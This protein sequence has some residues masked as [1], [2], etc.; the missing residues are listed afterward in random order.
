MKGSTTVNGFDGCLELVAHAG[1]VQV[2]LNSIHNFPADFHQTTTS[3]NTS[4]SAEYD[5]DSKPSTIIAHDGK[6]SCIIDPEI[7]TWL[8]AETTLA[9][10]TAIS[11]DSKQFQ[12][13][14]T[15]PEVSNIVACLNKVLM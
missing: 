3:T 15:E 6:I 11:I 14:S 12:Y 7:T 5:E 8:S 2:Q 4:T 9:Q 1:D 10:K 13:H